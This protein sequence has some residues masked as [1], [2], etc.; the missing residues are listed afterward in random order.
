[1]TDVTNWCPK[2]GAAPASTGGCVYCAAER[3][4][5]VAGD[6]RCPHGNF[7]GSV[8]TQCMSELYGRAQTVT[9]LQPS[10]TDARALLWARTYHWGLRRY[11]LEANT[12]GLAVAA[13][14]NAVS[15]F[16]E[17]YLGRRPT[18]G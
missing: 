9:V 10:T 1:M 7:L 13:A 15:D 8:C 11:Y 4:G 12:R 14:N 17:H 3:S 18:K 16:D 2:H 6:P 5:G